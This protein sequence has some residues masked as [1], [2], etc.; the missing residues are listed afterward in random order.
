[1]LKIYGV[2]REI[3]IFENVFISIIFMAILLIF[4]N[5]LIHTIHSFHTLFL[6]RHID[7]HINI[8]FKLYKAQEKLPNEPKKL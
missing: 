6:P 8:T 1:M 3:Y 7:I 4:G 5:N 2:F